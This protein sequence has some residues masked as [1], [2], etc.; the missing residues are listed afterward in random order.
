[1][2]VEREK[3][4]RPIVITLE[5][6]NEAATLWHWLNMDY[7]ETGEEYAEENELPL[8]D[9]KTIAQ[10]FWMLDAAMGEDLVPWGNGDGKP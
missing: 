2:K 3:G 6:E 5:N 7:D 10:L 9:P 8:R 1:M 4:F